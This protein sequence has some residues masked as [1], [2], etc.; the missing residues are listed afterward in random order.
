[1][2]Q[3]RPRGQGVVT[4]R[5]A[6][7]SAP[8]AAWSAERPSDRCPRLRARPRRGPV[9]GHGRGGSVGRRPAAHGVRGACWPTSTTSGWRSIRWWC[10]SSRTTPARPDRGVRCSGTGR[11]RGPLHLA[12][13]R[14]LA[15]RG[16]VAAPPARPG[17]RRRGRVIAGPVGRRRVPAQAARSEVEGHPQGRRHLEGPNDG[18]LA[19]QRACGGSRLPRPSASPTGTLWAVAYRGKQAPEEIVKGAR[20]G[21]SGAANRRCV[22][23]LAI[24]KIAVWTSCNREALSQQSPPPRENTQW[25][26]NTLTSTPA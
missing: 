20:G 5:D 8:D 4:A 15:A 3:A 26:L 21:A 9:R 23:S 7:A 13:A 18:H 12:P 11:G 14:V 22:N 2:R 10:R 6:P 1:M 25:R 16:V 19:T 24:T 17:R